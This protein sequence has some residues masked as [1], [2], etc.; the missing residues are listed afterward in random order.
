MQDS[1]G[2]KYDLFDI[3]KVGLKWKKYIIGF[4][5]LVGMITAVYFL[6]QKNQYKAYGS[7]FP[8]SAVMSGR[9]NLF[10]ETHQEW[11]DMFG[12][13]NE[14][15]RVYVIANS[16]D[17]VSYLID[18]FDMAQH[19]KIDTNHP[20]AAQK[21]YKRFAKSYSVSRTGFRHI[22]I[23]FTDEDHDLAYRIVNEAMNRTET[24]VRKLFANVNRQLAL[25]LEIRRDSISKQMN[26]LTDSL[27]AMRVKY[28]IY[29][30][31][32]PGRQNLIAPQAKGSGLAYAEGLEKI[33]AIE[34]IK[35]RLV[36]D[37]AKY[38]SIANEFKTSTFEGFP[39]IHVAQWATPYGPKAGPYRTIGVLGAMLAA[40][41]FGLF[42]SNIIEVF[43]VNKHRYLS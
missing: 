11:I 13:E 24:L 37:R 40:F 1:Q 3:I 9:I 18:K 41:V 2:F 36:T 10:R 38:T 30:V 25:S 28:G 42:L 5:L 35:D 8:A 19:Y 6:L 34:E 26:E 32:S 43:T 39:M 17:V 7:F 16:A 12:G 31:L 22:E 27:V 23:T 29:D 21:I 33:Q 4:T 14:V 15:D 20:Q